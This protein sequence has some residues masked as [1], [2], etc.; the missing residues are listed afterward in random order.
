MPAFILALFLTAGLVQPAAPITG[1]VLDPSGSAVPDAVVRL[2]VGGTAINE[3]RTATD[4]R[5]AFPAD[6]DVG[7]PARV[8]VTAAGFAPATV[9]VADASDELRI[10]L[11]P[12]PFFEA[13]NVT[14]S[15]TDVPRA[16]P[17]VT[18]TVIPA[19]ELLS[20]AAISVDDALKMVPGFTLFRRTSSR[21][22]N[23]TAQGVSLRG[24]G[25]TGASRSL[26]LANGI[27]LNDA[28]G[29]WVYWDKVPQAAIDRIEVQRGSGTDLYGAD[30]VGGVVQILTVR[31]GRPTGR[32]ILEG[33]NM[34]TGRVSIF[35][36]SRSN[37]L[38]YSGGGQ[39]F[40]TGGYIPVAVEQD[41]GLAPRGPVDSELASEHTSGLVTLGYQAANGWRADA[42][43]SVFDED[44]LN[45]TPAQINSTA[46]RSVSV[47]V[48][49]GVRGGLLSLRGFGGT[50]GYVQTFSAVN[51]TR[52]SEALNRVQ[53]V[54]TE[55][56][57]FGAQWVQPLNRHA[58]L[59]GAETRHIDGTT[60]ET[61]ITAQGLEQATTRAGG[62]QR[63][64]SGFAQATLNFSDRLTVVG[65]AQTL[66]W[67]ST[68][69]NT[70]FD[71]TLSSFNPRGSFTYRLTEVVAVRGSAYKGFRAP[72]LNEF[73]RGFRVG[74]TQTN[75]N[76]AL[77][78]ER[79]KGGDVGL[80]ISRGAVSARITGFWNILDDAITNITLSS[81][82]A[83]IT[84][85]RANADKV[86]A[87]G[88]EFEGDA[89]LQSMLTVT[90]AAGILR[91]KFTGSGSLSGNQ[92][93]QVPR[94]N[95]AIGARYANYGWTGSV[96]LR[97]TGAQFEDDQNAFVLRRAT[98]V[99]V[100][101]GRNV[102]RQ[103]Q[104]F[105]AVE[106]LFDNE[107]DVGRTPIL[108]TGLPR[109]VRAGVQIALP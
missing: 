42:D 10:S 91:S 66:H 78:P 4:G 12:A 85:Q 59:V 7:R 83:L 100:Y 57:G 67:H 88:F 92:V 93:P 43:G 69:A 6:A 82:P 33:G 24:L 90:F 1:I 8:I 16:D 65:A 19:S 50:Q 14:S 96:Q 95:L 27:A 63:L 20:A 106:N 46:S 79:L 44:R 68:S 72:T 97:V 52:T 37:G 99:D 101:A 76:E 104:A 9:D 36:G 87:A 64:G 86:R 84:K 58:L 75:P 39:W 22:S 29:G 45:G 55:V 77:L 74:N 18:V 102:V 73:Y 94:Y 23:P 26:V 71:K 81:T 49:G 15:R 47:D 5:F 21:V 89:R 17:T 107:Y 61:P 38:V 28:F 70:G 109:A 48:A 51:A 2:E 13:V 54:P 32:A 34:D 53:R 3:M 62:T 105:V 108:T 56:I 40:T 60:I 98:V 25:G 35:A 103:V 31:P 30:A 80:L 41:A 11:E